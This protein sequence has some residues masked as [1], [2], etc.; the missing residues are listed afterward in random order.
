MGLR[1]LPQHQLAH[2]LQVPE[3]EASTEP[4]HDL[5]MGLTTPSE[6][7]LDLRSLLTQATRLRVDDRRGLGGESNLPV[8][9]L[10]LL[11]E[12]VGLEGPPELLTVVE[13]RLGLATSVPLVPPLPYLISAC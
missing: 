11:V 3:Y 7:P 10:C 6:K 9:R 5:C 1:L 8:H 13:T 2:I 4:L 12:G